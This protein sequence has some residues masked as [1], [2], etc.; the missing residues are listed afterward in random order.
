MTTRKHRHAAWLRRWARPLGALL[1]MLPAAAWIGW[2][3]LILIQLG[4][5]WIA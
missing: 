5:R 4:A 2:S 1:V 3:A